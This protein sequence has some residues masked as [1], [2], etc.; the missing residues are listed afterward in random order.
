MNETKKSATK[1]LFDSLAKLYKQGQLLLMDSDR[2]MEERGW[3]PM[4]NT[5]LAELS[6][7]MNSPQRW[8]ARWAMRFYMPAATEEEEL[9]IDR[10][11]F[12]SIHFASDVNTGLETRVDEPLV[13]AGRL[14]YDKPMTLKEANETYGYWMCKY[15]F[16]G[17]P[18]DTWED[19]RKTGQSRWYEN[20]KG[21]ETFIVPLYDITSS[22][23]LKESVIDRLLTVQE[24]EERI[25]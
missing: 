23:K 22:E 6:Y 16:I 25:T 7:S 21:S 14:I 18:H 20:L 24:Q 17:K 5:A 8:F 12:V 10:I 1:A 11:L 19:W 13:C 4:H 9:M 2:L 3:A 15:W